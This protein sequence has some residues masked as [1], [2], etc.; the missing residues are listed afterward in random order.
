MNLRNMPLFLI[1]GFMVGASAHYY[2]GEPKTITKFIEVEKIIEKFVPLE[3]VVIKEVPTTKTVIQTRTIY[4]PAEKDKNKVEQEE[5]YCMALNIY[6]E[7]ANQ[8][9]AGMIAVAR[10]VMNRVNDRRFPGTVCD[11]IYEGPVRES[12]RT[13]NDPNINKEDREFYPVK[14]RCQFSW[15]CDG[16]KDEVINTENNIKWKVANAIAYEV[17]AYNKWKGML[18]GANHYHAEYVKPEW[19]K[20]MTLV[21]HIDDHIFYRA[22]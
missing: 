3:K 8:S 4:I 21:A 20:R 10:V 16:K 18:E 17:L 13:K 9:Q 14:H 6:R 2:M 1:I 22:D 5:L 11:V 7:A 15:Y 12:W 19:R